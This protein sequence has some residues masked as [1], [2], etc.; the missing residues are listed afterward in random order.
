MSA[1]WLGLIATVSVGIGTYLMRSVFIVALADRNLPPAMLQALR[2]VA[3]SVLAALVMSSVLGSAGEGSVP[4]TE[5]AALGVGG[6][7][8][9]RTRSIPWLLVA[10]MVTL[11]V[12]EGIV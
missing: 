6:V 11:W 7:V 10:G 1:F 3:P 9:W 2:F 12:L 5:V 8:G 4:W